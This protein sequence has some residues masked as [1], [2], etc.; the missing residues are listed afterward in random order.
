MGAKF[1]KTIANQS[2][3]GRNHDLMCEV[4]GGSLEAASEMLPEI[5]S[6]VAV[7][8]RRIELAPQT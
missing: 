5:A 8:E 2:P 3:C 4:C 6:D 7:I 1:Q